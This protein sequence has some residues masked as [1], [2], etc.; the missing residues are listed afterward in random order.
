M[1]SSSSDSVA[2]KRDEFL[3]KVQ[4]ESKTD[5]KS[6]GESGDGCDPPKPRGTFLEPAQGQ[7]RRA[8]E[9]KAPSCGYRGG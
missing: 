3:N 2:N 6:P 8:V 9:R 4:A 5:P 7:Q 1:S